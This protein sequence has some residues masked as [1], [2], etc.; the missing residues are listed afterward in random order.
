MDSQV[1][2]E[3]RTTNRIFVCGLV[4]FLLYPPAII[5]R[6]NY[7]K[8]IYDMIQL[9]LFFYF[10][11]MKNEAINLNRYKNNVVAISIAILFST[12]MNNSDIVGC[13][14]MIIKVLNVCFISN[15]YL[16]RIPRQ[17]IQ[18]CCITLWLYTLVN[19]ITLFVFPNGMYANNRG[20]MT[21]YFLGEDNV[22]FSLYLL[23]NC[24]TLILLVLYKGKAF[25]AFLF[26]IIN[27]LVFVFHNDIATG[28]ACIFAFLVLFFIGTSRRVRMFINYKVVLA[29]H[30]IIIAILLYFQSKS[31]IFLFVQS[32]LIRNAQLSGRTIIWQRVI[33][34]IVKYPVIGS[35]YYRES[36]FPELIGLT[37]AHN[38]FLQ[39]VLWG[40]FVAIV[41]FILNLVYLQMAT[42]KEKST[43]SLR[44]ALTIS[45]FVFLLHEQVE[46]GYGEIL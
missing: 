11:V 17:F 16:E 43:S 28:K 18:G 12:V 8:Y 33:S 24:L 42:D 5:L 15:F 3:N 38:Y 2:E 25:P 37:N 41:L 44:Y 21:C 46:S 9:L 6:T 14:E 40:G 22:G 30:L 26:S 45:I 27:S 4:F 34:L 1:H 35:G 23:A 39:L 20:V 10:G 31:S 19:S 13:F 29:G 7:S 32:Q 36:L